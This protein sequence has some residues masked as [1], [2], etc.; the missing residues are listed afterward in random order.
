MIRFTNNIPKVIAEME[1]RAKA[2]SLATA[3]AIATKARANA[4]VDTGR[5]RSSIQARATET[6]A[7][8]V[9]G[10]EYG[11]FVELGTKD[12]RPQPYLTPAVESERQ[13]FEERGSKVFG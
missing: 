12:Q 2:A 13:P 1:R 3:E 9:V 10:V 11:Q 6:G 7:E 4:P 5:L 8:V